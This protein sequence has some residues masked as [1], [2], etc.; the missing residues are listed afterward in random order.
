MPVVDDMIL[1]DKE[2]LKSTFDE[3]FQVAM[4][5]LCHCYDHKEGFYPTDCECSDRQRINE[6]LSLLI[7]EHKKVLNKYQFT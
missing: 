6:S 7:Q 3:F 4:S 1:T 2:D 5:A